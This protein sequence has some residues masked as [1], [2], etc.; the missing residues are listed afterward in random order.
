MEI[1]VEKGK[2][3]LAYVKEGV[4]DFCGVCKKKFTNSDMAYACSIQKKL[5]C[6]S[7]HTY[8]KEVKKTPKV[9]LCINYPGLKVIQDTG[10]VLQPNG[11]IHEHLFVQVQVIK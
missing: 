3:R 8:E 7:C 2:G 4:E 10:E 5:F 9:W 6:V 1:K 11:R